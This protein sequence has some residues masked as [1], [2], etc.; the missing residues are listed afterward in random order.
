MT[1]NNGFKTYLI[2]VS[3][4][5][6][7]NSS[8]YNIT[9]GLLDKN[10]FIS[11]WNEKRFDRDGILFETI[12]NKFKPSEVVKLFAIYFFKELDKL[13]PSYILNDQ[14]ELYYKV[15]DQFTHIEI[16]YQSDIDKIKSHCV[17][18]KIK[19]KELI[20]S[21]EIFSLKLT[22]PTLLILNRLFDIQ[23]I[24]QSKL[25]KKI[26]SNR[27]LYLEKLEVIFNKE[28]SGKDWKLITKKHLEK[29]K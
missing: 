7:F 2:Y 12:S 29:G 21:L 20:H 19:M 9:N 25:E 22:L 16:A 14:Y 11:S 3:V 27:K 6:H 17:D 8:K 5:A 13:H 1:N 18:K 24:P 10:K 15:K 23:L 28:L 4:I 26:L